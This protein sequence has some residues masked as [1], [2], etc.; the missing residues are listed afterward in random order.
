MIAYHVVK[1]NKQQVKQLT[2][3]RA[4]IFSELTISAVYKSVY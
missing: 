3:E 2:N 4:I 1:V